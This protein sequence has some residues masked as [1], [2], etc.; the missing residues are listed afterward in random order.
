MAFC[1]LSVQVC[2]LPPLFLK[3]ARAAGEARAV[4]IE[5]LRAGA[6]WAGHA[7]VGFLVL[8]TVKYCKMDIL[9]RPLMDVD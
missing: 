6:G 1:C 4:R 3:A 7:V 8:A 2:V 5:R 9:K